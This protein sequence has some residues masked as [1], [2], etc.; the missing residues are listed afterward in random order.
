MEPKA[1]SLSEGRSTDVLFGVK[2]HKEKD[3][4][5]REKEERER[6]EKEKKEE[7][8]KRKH[9]AEKAKGEWV[10]EL[11]FCLFPDSTALVLPAASP[12][13]LYQ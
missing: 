4:E 10:S 13:L 7:E 11:L 6:R 12:Y 9:D 8:E 2:E 5:Q 3:A 1:D